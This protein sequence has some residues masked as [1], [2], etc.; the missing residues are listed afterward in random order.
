MRF[1]E[2]ALAASL[3]KGIA[4]DVTM[5]AMN[6]DALAMKINAKILRYVDACLSCNC[7]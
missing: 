6:T 2:A 1:A 5:S 3:D 7:E 4:R